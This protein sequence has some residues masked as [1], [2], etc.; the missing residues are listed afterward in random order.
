MCDSKAP[1]AWG[2]HV[3]GAAALVKHRANMVLDTPLSRGLF[4]FVRKNVLLSHMQTSKAI[5][6]VFVEADDSLFLD[7]NVEDQLISKTIKLPYLQQLTNNILTE[8]GYGSNQS[9]VLQLRDAV[10]IIDHEL[11]VWASSVPPTWSYSVARN[12]NPTPNPGFTPRQI[13]RYPNLYIARV[14]NMYRVSHLMVQ[15][16][17]LRV[18]SWLIEASSTNVSD[19]T[20]L[21]ERGRCLVNDTCA[22]VPYLLGH[23][24]TKIKLTTAEDCSMDNPTLPLSN[25]DGP[26]RT[27]RFSL[28]WPLHVGSSA[29]FVPELQREWMRKQLQHIYGQGEQLAKLVCETES[30]VLLGGNESFRFDCV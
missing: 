10:R 27:G 25:G 15:S 21:E 11:S 16:I 17:L 14:W 2:A 3:D 22:S 26:A 29:A 24:L 23:D 8:T 20:A 1:P 28:I 7:E 6:K 18:D 5:D 12:L 30:K 4:L 13:H 19:R 9:E